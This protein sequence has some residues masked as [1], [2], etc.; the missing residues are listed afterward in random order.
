M[1]TASTHNVTAT[2]CQIDILKVANNR[3]I[4][5]DQIVSQETWVNMMLD[6]GQRY[7]FLFSQNYG[8]DAAKIESYLTKSIVGNWFWN[9][10]KMKWMQDDHTYIYNKI[11]RH[12]YISYEQ[13]KC[14]LL[15]HETLE[16]ELLGLLELEN[17]L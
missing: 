16:Q 11:Q 10:W 13:Y 8:T 14:Y 15:R 5:I 6:Y 12:I 7:A 2:E 1:P 4:I 17:I 3:L 9:W